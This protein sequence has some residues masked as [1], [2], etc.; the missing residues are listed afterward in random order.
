MYQ[1]TVQDKLYTIQDQ[2]SFQ[3]NNQAEDAWIEKV[4]ANT[5]LLHRGQKQ[6]EVDVLKIDKDLKQLTIRVQGKKCVVSIKEPIDIKLEA[7][8]IK[9][10]E[11]KKV[12]ALKAAM[13][14]LILKIVVKEGDVVKAGEPLLIL[15][16]MKMENSFKAPN[17]VVI[18]KVH[19]TE[20]QAVE[21]G[22]EL[23]SFE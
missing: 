23:I 14:G 16:A 19:I 6:Y 20:K 1:I 4:S 17:D 18:K 13:S 8:G 10:T 9:T 3:M 2:E 15:E 11:V 7:I 22:Q 21:K 5:Y 12:N